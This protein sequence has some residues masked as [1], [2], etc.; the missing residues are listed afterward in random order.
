MDPSVSSWLESKGEQWPV[1][2][3]CSLG[4]SLSNQIVLPDN[5]VSRRHAI[6]HSQ[7]DHEFWLVDLGSSN[8][9]YL[10]GRRVSQ[11]TRLQDRDKIS[12]G[13]FLLVFRQPQGGDSTR[14]R[15]FTEVTLREIK[16]V[17]CWLLLADMVASTDLSK[18]LSPDELSMVTGRW[19]G[20]CKEIIDKNRGIINKFLGDGFFAYWPDGKDIAESVAQALRELKELQILD[21]PRFRVVLHF[22]EVAV[23]GT[24]TL[25]EESLMGKDVNYV[26]RME[27]LA[28]S[29]ERP[30]LMS[31]AAGQK[32]EKRIEMHDAGQHTMQ[33]FGQPESFYYF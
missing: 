20:S 24:A 9:T 4:R 6:I 11:P 18:K 22:G 16:T 28:G 19:L 23:G 8:G 10:N 5:K 27:K 25:G 33:G 26:F 1:A 13:D 12:I 17:R 29:L 14:D 2:A 21:S 30:C 32:L 7:G 3:S 31:R 15:T